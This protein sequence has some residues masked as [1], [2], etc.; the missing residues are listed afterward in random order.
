MQSWMNLLLI[1]G[2]LLIALWLLTRSGVVQDLV[3]R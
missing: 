3:N 2:T 1:L